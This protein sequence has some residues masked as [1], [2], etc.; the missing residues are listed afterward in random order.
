MSDTPRTDTV[1]SNDDGG[2]GYIANLSRISR[3]LERELNAA[4]ERIKKME[5]ENRLLKSRIHSMRSLD[6]CDDSEFGIIKGET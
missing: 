6:Y 2:S 3:Q 5:Q 1:V 4:N